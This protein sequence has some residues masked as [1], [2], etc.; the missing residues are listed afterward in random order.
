[1]GG[2]GGQGGGL[3]EGGRGGACLRDT[4]RTETSKAFWNRC[5]PSLTVSLPFKQFVAA[6]FIQSV[7]GPGPRSELGPH[8]VKAKW[9]QPALQALVADT[10]QW[11]KLAVLGV[12][13]FCMRRTGGDFNFWPELNAALAQIE[14]HTDFH[15][16]IVAGTNI[17]KVSVWEV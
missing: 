5:F 3:P 9:P 2:P 10:S 7:T 13:R 15:E 12:L 6:T 11:W 14:N 4:D 16:H 17:P 8:L 1:M